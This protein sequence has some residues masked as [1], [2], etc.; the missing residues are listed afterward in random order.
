M[1]MR[2]IVLFLSI[3][4]VSP[5]FGETNA[6]AAATNAQAAQ[7]VRRFI[8]TRI[9]KLNHASAVEVADKFNSMW[10]GEFG[11]TWK[12]AKMAVAFEES[13]SIMITAPGVILEACEKSILEL[14]REAK[15]VY[16][17]VVQR[18]VQDMIEDLLAQFLRKPIAERVAHCGKVRDIFQ[19][20]IPEKPTI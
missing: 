16:R 10:S 17:A 6:V 3:A 9:Y 18:F 20:A 19:Q 12:V 11:Q 14:D 8:D 7:P 15:Q 2:N 5:V 4:V 1:G 13:N